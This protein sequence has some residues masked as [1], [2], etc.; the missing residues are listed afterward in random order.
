MQPTTA[1]GGGEEEACGAAAPSRVTFRS[2]RRKRMQEGSSEGTGEKLEQEH[3][4]RER[5]R[6]PASVPQYN[7]RVLLTTKQKHP[8]PPE[9]LG[10]QV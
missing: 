10:D 1:N 9:G 8:L 7:W 4:L 6:K 5:K 3:G 2:S